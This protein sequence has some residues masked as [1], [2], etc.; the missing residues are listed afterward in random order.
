[1]AETSFFNSRAFWFATA[2]FFFGTF[3]PAVAA[4]SEM[5]RM[6]NAACNVDGFLQNSDKDTS[7]MVARSSCYFLQRAVDPWAIAPNMVD[8]KAH[9]DAFKA[10]AGP[11]KSFV[12]G[13]FLPEAISTS[14]L[15]FT[16]LGGRER[17][18][19]FSTFCVKNQPH[20]AFGPG[21]CVADINNPAYQNYLLVLEQQMSAVGVT[22]FEFGQVMMMDPN[23]AASP[24][25]AEMR[26]V[27]ASAGASILIG[28][29]TNR[30]ADRAYLSN[31][32]YIVG[33]SYMNRF[34]AVV[35]DGLL[36]GPTAQATA[37]ALLWADEYRSRAKNV[38][39]ETDWW[40]R[41]DDVHRFAELSSN[42]RVR[43]I[44]SLYNF[45]AKL[46]VGFVVPFS[47]PIVGGPTIASTC[48]GQSENQYS[49]SRSYT[50]KDEDA[51]NAMFR[52]GPTSAQEPA[53]DP[54]ILKS[55][56][57]IQNLSGTAD[58]VK[59]MMQGDGNLVLSVNDE[60]HSDNGKVLWS[61]QSARASCNG[62]CTT[63]IQPDGNLVLYDKHHNPYWHTNTSGHP[64]A[65]LVV[66]TTIPYL[67]I[68]DPNQDI[69]WMNS[70]VFSTLLLPQ[71][72]YVQLGDTR[73][74]L[75]N[76]GNL[77][78][79]KGSETVWQSASTASGC[80][81]SLCQAVFASSSG[82][83]LTRRASV[84]VASVLN[85]WTSRTNGNEGAMLKLSETAPYMEIVNPNNKVLWEAR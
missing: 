32:D 11:S 76:D 81:V 80:G 49:A 34:G 15:T 62:D 46:G 19:D 68:I 21:T 4:P 24:F 85:Y 23:F 22:V 57:S 2:L 78:V 20:G 50:C 9:I 58:A 38:F 73:L 12:I 83:F 72:A 47:V 25:Y 26:R 3:R 59:L 35:P 29:Q 45:Y 52:R 63:W 44:Q 5:S 30:I 75:E 54:I 55:G 53:G 18:Y 43:V 17:I 67:Q 82:Q 60:G 79:S 65:A 13:I 39:I 70:N 61:S 74:A 40:D 1:M 27:G 42:D 8:I 16:E 71:N 10:A 31:F 56:D 48:H 33:G 7:D 6:K 84:D 41:D 64:L 37:T 66:S 51:F 69:L 28:G 14:K 77:V 36:S